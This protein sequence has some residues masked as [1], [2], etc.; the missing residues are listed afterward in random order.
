MGPKKKCQREQL[1]DALSGT[2]NKIQAISNIVM[3]PQKSDF[4]VKPIF[5][6]S[7]K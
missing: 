5:R 7:Q 6:L 1:I 4:F 3:G 2:I